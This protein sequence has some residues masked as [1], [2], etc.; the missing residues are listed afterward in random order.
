MAHSTPLRVALVT[1][2]LLGAVGASCQEDS[3]VPDDATLEAAGAVIGTITIHNGSIFDLEDPEE[4]TRLLRAADHLHVT[5]KERVIRRQLT[6]A[7]GDRYSRAALDESERTLRHNGYLYDA[8]IRATS[9]D[10]HTVDVGVWTRDVWTLRP[11]IG[12]HRSGGVNAAHFGLQD[13]NF[14]GLGKNLEIA[15][16]NGVDRTQTMVHYLDPM[17]FRTHARL[18]LGY[19]S[20]SDG[21]SAL[22]ALERPFWKLDERWSAGVHAET[23][24]K[25]DSLYAFGAITHQF[26]ERRVSGRASWGRRLEGSGRTT[27]RFLAGFTYDRSLFFPLA[28]ADPA[29][30]V[31]DDRTLSY[32]WI[33][34]SLLRDGFV[35]SRDMNKM[36][37]TEDLNLGVDFTATLGFASPAFGADRTA[38]MV[39]LS[40]HDGMSPGAG[41]IVTLDAGL[42]GR[43]TSSA[44]EDG[45]L[46]LAARYYHRDSDVRL[47]YLGLSGSAAANPDADHQLLL[48]GD[49]GLRGYPLRYALGERRLLLTLEERFFVHRE[50]FHLMRIGGAIF[51]DVGKAW[52]EVPDPAAHLGVLEDVGFG[53]RFGQ[54]R[55]AHAAMVKLDVAVP[56]NTPEGGVHPQILV[57]TGETF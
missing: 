13:A 39:D 35:R 21:S 44:L 53:L 1:L 48:G 7:P 22:L 50:F 6:F 36:G 55:S 24:D 31:P 5:T 4:N 26:Q 15:R 38:G 30:T 11:S 33:G 18:S 37:R 45:R 9:F 47:F 2:S 57:T 17:V 46:D 49:N 8:S 16:V 54:T 40:W 28:E 25:V 14:L 43:V 52:G 41:Q 29:S 20:N 3:P 10:G 23:E 27:R 32:P 34:V 56:L 12:F 42:K 19:S 51:A